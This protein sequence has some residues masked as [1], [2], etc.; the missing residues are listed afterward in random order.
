MSS[1]ITLALSGRWCRH[2]VAA[3]VNSNVGEVGVIDG[4]GQR[5]VDDRA[6]VV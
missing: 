1:M 3:C 4:D 6:L 2:H 5:A